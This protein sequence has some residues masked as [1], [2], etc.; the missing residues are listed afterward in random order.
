MARQHRLAGGEGVWQGG[1]Q[2]GMGVGGGNSGRDSP[3]HSGAVN[4]TEPRKRSSSRGSHQRPGEACARVQQRRKGSGGRCCREG[5]AA[6][7]S[8]PG[9]AVPCCG[10]QRRVAPGQR[11]RAQRQAW[12]RAWPLRHVTERVCRLRRECARP[13]GS[14]PRV[15]EG[16]ARA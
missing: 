1:Q 8:Q 3:Q 15:Y 6:G 12:W 7:G 11:Q 10:H 14:A 13:K 2:C 5:Q 16:D 9:C 4:A